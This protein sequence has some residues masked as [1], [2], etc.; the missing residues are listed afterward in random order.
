MHPKSDYPMKRPQTAGTAS[1]GVYHVGKIVSSNNCVFQSIDQEN[2]VGN[3]AY[4]EFIL[5]HQTAG[6]CIAAQIKSGASYVSNDLFSIPSDSAHRQ[7][8][9]THILPV[10]GIVYNPESDIA[11][12]VDLTKYLK[13]YKETGGR[14][15]IPVPKGNIFNDDKFNEFRSHFLPYG[16]K[17]SDDLHFVEALAGLAR[18]DDF[19]AVLSSIRSLF[20]F[21]RNRTETWFCIISCLRYFR[22][23][24]IMQHLVVVL[25]HVPGH[26]DI[27]WGKNNI[28][29]EATRKEAMALL[30]RLPTRDDVLAMITAIDENGID[31]GQIGQCVHSIV[32]VVGG[33][34]EMLTSLA[35]DE[36]VDEGSRYWAFLL[37][38]IVLQQRDLPRTIALI[39]RLKDNMPDDH[40]VEV[41]QIYETLKE[42]GYI[43][44]Y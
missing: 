18:I 42:S 4:I 38:V 32:E 7:Y 16:S 23:S 40:S 29:E 19:E 14:H 11:R 34:V 3:D 6:C 9:R 2:D 28:I 5:E 36:S 12:W 30:R 37:M 41:Q 20:A 24:R 17:Y 25:C 31:R 27:F 15:A 35:A 39:E 8:W 22:D 21:H 10:V 43:H 33:N 1:Q 26:G 44:F 13:D